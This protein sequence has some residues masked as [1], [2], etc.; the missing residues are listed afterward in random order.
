MSASSSLREDKEAPFTIIGQDLYEKHHELRNL[1]ETSRKNKTRRKIPKVLIFEL[2]GQSQ[3]IIQPEASFPRKSQLLAAQSA[4]NTS[5]A[6]ST[7][8]SETP[9]KIQHSSRIL[10]LKTT[11]ERANLSE[12][13]CNFLATF[14]PAGSEQRDR[15]L[16][17]ILDHFRAPDGFEDYN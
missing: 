15:Q 2:R 4:K 10:T 9:I 8:Q 11:G 14:F 17:Y 5:T 13:E 6:T 16:E 3:P 12:N 7:I 1:C